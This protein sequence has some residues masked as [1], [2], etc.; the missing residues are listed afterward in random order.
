MLISPFNLGLCVVFGCLLDPVIVLRPLLLKLFLLFPFLSLF[1]HLV[2]LLL[3]FPAFLFDFNRFTHHLRQTAHHA[4]Q[5][6]V[7]CVR[8][9]LIRFTVH[10]LFAFHHGTFNWLK[11]LC[12]LEGRPSCLV[13]WFRVC[14]G[15]FLL[16]PHESPGRELI[17]VDNNGRFVNPIFFSQNRRMAFMAAG[18]AGSIKCR[19]LSLVE[20][21]LI[22]FLYRAILLPRTVDV[23]VEDPIDIVLECKE[24]LVFFDVFLLLLLPN[25]ELMTI[26]IGLS[27]VAS[28]DVRFV[29]ILAQILAQNVLWLARQRLFLKERMVQRLVDRQAVI[30]VQHQQAV[31][32]V[33]ERFGV[34]ILCL[35]LQVLLK[36][37][38]L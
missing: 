1:D 35:I 11:A 7:G 9:L 31:D 22:T 32:E 5:L 10:I 14:A 21:I 3:F 20:L 6:S 37:A 38:L 36:P 29:R 12:T 30:R 16:R 13:H 15:L 27:A 25:Y 33:V 17:I 18:S 19:R 34:A 24:F 28:V 8:G 26:I 23:H 2:P 4:K